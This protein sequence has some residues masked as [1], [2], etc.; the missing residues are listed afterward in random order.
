M[1]YVGL[2]FTNPSM[3]AMDESMHEWEQCLSTGS[4]HP[5]LPGALEKQVAQGRALTSMM[6][7]DLSMH[8]IQP[9]LDHTLGRPKF[10]IHKV[11]K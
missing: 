10:C 2:Q 3:V 6:A 11:H 1:T 7:S 5:L 9:P 8:P 4:M